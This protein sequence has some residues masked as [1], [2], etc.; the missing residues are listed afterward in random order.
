VPHRILLRAERLAYKWADLVITPNESYAKIAVSRGRVPEER[1]HVVR[2]AP[3]VSVW[4]PHVPQQALREGADFVVCFVGAVGRQDGVD[5]LIRTM[6]WLRENDPSRN[7]LCLVAGSGDALGDAQQ[8][9][10]SCNVK[11]SV[12]F[13]GWIADQATLRDIVASSDVGVEPARSNSFTDS[14]TMI[15]VTEYLAAGRPVV[16]YNLP[17][18]RVTV[19]DAGVLVPPELGFQGLGAA[20]LAMARDPSRVAKLAEKA[21]RRLDEAGLSASRSQEALLCTYLHAREL[22]KS[23]GAPW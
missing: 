6:A 17:E 13:L 14:S 23:R 5:E 22:G 16:A 1:V 2:D 20:L 3:D 19:G 10:R 4:H 12:R 11:G 9:A 18:H 15:K 7:F 21:R 8:L